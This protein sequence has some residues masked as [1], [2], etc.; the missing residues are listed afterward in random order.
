MIRPATGAAPNVWQYQDVKDKYSEASDGKSLWTQQWQRSQRVCVHGENC[1]RSHCE[2]GKASQTIHLISGQFVVLWG[3]LKDC[4]PRGKTLRLVQVALTEPVPTGETGK[5][6]EVEHPKGETENPNRETGKPGEETEKSMEVE[7]PNGET[8][9]PMEVEHPNGETE[10]QK[11]ETEK[12]S[13]DSATKSGIPA[14]L[15]S[16]SGGSRKGDTLLTGVRIP[17]DKIETLRSKL[18][19]MKAALV[20]EGTSAIHRTNHQ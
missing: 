4:V 5:P 1:S 2:V 12:P 7:H 11:G 16:A 15:G 17:R 10:N 13:V 8:E 6:M 19:G 3:F 9:K 14:G 18:Q 20:S